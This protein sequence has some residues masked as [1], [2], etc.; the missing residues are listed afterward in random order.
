VSN[1]STF[2]VL[3]A[4]SQLFTALNIKW[5]PVIY[6]A[7]LRYQ[8]SDKYVDHDIPPRAYASGDLKYDL[9]PREVDLLWSV[10]KYYNGA[11]FHERTEEGQTNSELNQIGKSYPP[12]LRTLLATSQKIVNEQHRSAIGRLQGRGFLETD[13]LTRTKIEY[14][15]TRRGRTKIVEIFDKLYQES[16]HVR[17]EFILEGDR[18]E[19]LTHRFLVEA[20]ISTMKP[21]RA[22][23]E[24]YPTGAG[25]M[26]D[27]ILEYSDQISPK[28]IYIEAFTGHNDYN[29]TIKKYDEWTAQDVNVVWMFPDAEIAARLF[30]AL[31]QESTP[32]SMDN[33]PFEN[34]GNFRVNRLENYFYRKESHHPGFI[35]FET[36]THV[37]ESRPLYDRLV[38]K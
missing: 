12:N 2:L 4:S 38:G 17:N 27:A 37:I 11:M 22:T 35:G 5:Y 24:K 3:I 14:V 26:P 31:E 21:K 32:F 15:P 36:A 25:H 29:Q 23:V 6:S 7:M 13:Y 30:N 20:G 8:D 34:P 33:A 19:S 18:N 16:R 9:H 28:S 10:M 1:D